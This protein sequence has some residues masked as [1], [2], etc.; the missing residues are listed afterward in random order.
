MRQLAALPPDQRML[1]M[2]ETARD[3]RPSV[4]RGDLHRRLDGLLTT[5]DLIRDELLAVRSAVKDRG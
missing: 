2:A 3:S 1:I 5:L 4:K